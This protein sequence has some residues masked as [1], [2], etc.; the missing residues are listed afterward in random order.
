MKL[1][2]HIPATQTSAETFYIVNNSGTEYRVSAPFEI[3]NLF[4]R[5]WSAYVNGRGARYVTHTKPGKA[6]IEF[7]KTLKQ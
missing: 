4:K 1:L 7:A 5:D 2:Q 6:V 3:A